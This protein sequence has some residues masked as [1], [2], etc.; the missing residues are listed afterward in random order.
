M[1]PT[2]TPQQFVEKWRRVMVKKRSDYQKHFGDL[3]YMLGSSH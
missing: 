1:A 3:Y 2:L